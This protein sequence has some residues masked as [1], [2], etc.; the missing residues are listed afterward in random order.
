MPAITRGFSLIEGVVLI[1]LLGIAGA[2]ALPRVTHIANSA[3]ATEVLALSGNLRSAATAAHAQYVAAGAR[4]STTLLAGRTVKLKHGYPDA[5]RGG[6]GN[7]L[8]NWDGFTTVGG[9]DAVTFS[10][11]DAPL[12]AQCSVT[13]HDAADAT[14]GA[15]ITNINTSGC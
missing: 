6:I 4:E 12:G 5:G 15:V 7:A 14:S 3:R 1:T 9:T 13:Y 11:T 8:A 2:F 10:K